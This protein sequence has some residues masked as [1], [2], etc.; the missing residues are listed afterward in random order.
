MFEI[1]IK[2]IIIFIILLFIY[3]WYRFWKWNR[4]LDKNIPLWIIVNEELGK[5]KPNFELAQNNLN[6]I[7]TNIDEFAEYFNIENINKW[8][9]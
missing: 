7:Q 3:N 8:K 1:A 5:D 6:Q 4:I 2:A 9:K